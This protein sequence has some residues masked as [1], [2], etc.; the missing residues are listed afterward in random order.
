MGMVDHVKYVKFA[1]CKINTCCIDPFSKRNHL[2]V[3][4]AVID[5]RLRSV[6]V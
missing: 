3:K 4:I 2:N 6:K 5:V 1:D